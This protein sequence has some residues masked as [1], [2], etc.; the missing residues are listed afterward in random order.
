VPSRDT[1]STM[2]FVELTGL[3]TQLT[4]KAQLCHAT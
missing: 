3:A 2:S 1:L 4:S